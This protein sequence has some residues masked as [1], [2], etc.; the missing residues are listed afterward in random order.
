M[1]QLHI[2]SLDV[3][4]GDDPWSSTIWLDLTR[5][6]FEQADVEGS[7][8]LIPGVAGMDVGFFTRRRRLLE[9]QGHV[10]G[11][12]GTYAERS[13]SW[14]DATQQLMGVMQMYLSP[15]L[16]EVEGDY[17]GIPSGTTAS[18]N[19]RCIRMLGGP[20][21]NRMSFQAW[22]FSLECID[23]PPEWVLST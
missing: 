9:L 13:E 5:G 4:N 17:L 8:D 21:L 10:R 19:A 11:E 1:G 23:S 6:Y 7:D 2:R 20:V 14:H 15:G 22:T 12:G 16:V 18:L 3:Q